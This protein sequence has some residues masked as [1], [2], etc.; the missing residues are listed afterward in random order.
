LNQSFFEK[1]IELRNHYRLQQLE[2]EQRKHYLAQQLMHVDALL[3]E[4]LKNSNLVESLVELRHQCQQQVAECE[5][6]VAHS[7][8]QL[9]HVNAL[10][11]DQIVQQHE[12]SALQATV[13]QKRA[14]TE[15]HE[16]ADDELPK[17]GELKKGL[18][19][20]PTPLDETHNEAA[21]YFL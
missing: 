17:E 13:A 7:R 10:L 14:L 3:L 11:A 19:N 15:A 9:T 16:L 8:E 12:H 2:S 20:L 5:R 18:D 4:Q 1:L 21:N 6:Q